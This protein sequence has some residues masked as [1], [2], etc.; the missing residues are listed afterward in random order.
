MTS[1]E[2]ARFREQVEE[3]VLGGLDG[4]TRTALL[5]HAATCP[6]CQVAVDQLALVADRLLLAVPE[7]EPPAGFEGRVLERLVPALSSPVPKGDDRRKRRRA[8]AAVAA[9][10]MLLAGASLALVYSGSREEGPYSG[11]PGP[12]AQPATGP[13]AVRSGTIVR[14][15]GSVV[16]AVS[17]VDQPRPLLLVTID[18]PRPSNNVVTCELVMADGV[19]TAVGTWNYDDVAKGAWAVGID[20]SLLTAVR[21]NVRDAAGAILSSAPLA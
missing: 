3:L 5:N 21:M 13:R 11:H 2:C 18:R 20:R 4:P 10:V 6:A 14:A 8:L 12:A 16:G 1:A 15:D 19:A 7:I 17:L 9:V